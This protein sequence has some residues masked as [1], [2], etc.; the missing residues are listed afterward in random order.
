[1]G[2]MHR[3]EV[4]RSFPQPLEVVFR[5]YTDHTRWGEWAGFGP[6]WLAAEGSPE[7]DGVGCVRAF[8]RAPGLRERITRFEPPRHMDY[9]IVSGNFPMA[10]HLGEVEFEPQGAGTRVNW[11]V[12]FRSRLP[13][14]G[15]LIER[16]LR[17]L[18]ERVLANLARDL[19][20]RHPT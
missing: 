17:M 19:D 4:S 11:R 6:V 2:A 7:R 18:F 16:G 10:D 13:L 14:V 8:S 12:T 3:V 15:S 20:R 9:R 1:M 5:R